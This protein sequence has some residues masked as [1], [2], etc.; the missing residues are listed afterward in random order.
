MDTSSTDSDKS[1]SS[2]STIFENF[3]TVKTKH[4]IKSGP[5]KYKLKLALYCYDSDKVET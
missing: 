1:S 2:T 4:L 3:K 5:R